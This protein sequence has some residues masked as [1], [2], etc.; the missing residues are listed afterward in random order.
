MADTKL[1]R[2]RFDDYSAFEQALKALKASSITQYDAYGPVN[3]TELEEY[4]PHKGSAVR[5]SATAWALIGMASFF[6]LCVLAS[7]VFPLVVGGKPP[8]SRVPFVVVTYEGTILL[9][10]LATVAAVVLLARLAPWEP[11]S[12]YDP[13]FSS[14]TYGVDIHCTPRA[15]KEAI[16]LMKNAGAVEI[17]EQ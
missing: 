6:F 3:L 13:R 4:M 10:A 9:G 11:P 1:I 7:L 8:V 16:E 17:D 2:A 5:I 14:D 15:C 12:D